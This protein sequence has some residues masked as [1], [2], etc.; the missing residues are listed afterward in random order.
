MVD[1]TDDAG[2]TSITVELA[3]EES[4][5]GIVEESNVTVA[6]N[7]LEQYINQSEAEITD[8][9]PDHDDGH[10]R[11]KAVVGDEDVLFLKTLR[12]DKVISVID[13]YCELVAYRIADAFGAPVAPACLVDHP[14]TGPA[15]A[16]R[17]YGRDLRETSAPLVDIGVDE[18]LAMLYAVELWVQNYDDKDRHFM[19]EETDDGMEVRYIDHG[20]ALYRN[21]VNKLDAPDDVE[22]VTPDGRAGDDP[23][24][25]GVEEMGD[26]ERCLKLIKGTSDD[27][28][29]EIVDWSLH[30]LR[31]TTSSTIEDFLTEEEFHREAA[32]RL[33]RKRRDEIRDLAEERLR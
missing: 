28:I 11:K 3:V 32:I 12:N 17:W 24:K 23:S 30:Q 5:A 10:G 27:T 19:L 4:L 16:I 15:L 20:H 26:I 2:A 21:W 29:E 13:L 33:L 18:D 6:T 9:D 14:D 7:L 22:T 1:E 31:G 25:Y 8:L